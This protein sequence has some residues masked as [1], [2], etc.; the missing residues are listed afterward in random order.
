MTASAEYWQECISEA[1]EECG[2]TIT[3]EQIASIAEAVEGAHENYGMAFYQPP[4]SDRFNEIEREH[5]DELDALRREFDTYRGTAEKTVGRILRQHSDTIIS[6]T[7]DGD[8]LR[9]DGRT[10]QIA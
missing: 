3:Q 2:L 1:A 6:I 8:V 5:K 7:E 4:P 9:H 10:E